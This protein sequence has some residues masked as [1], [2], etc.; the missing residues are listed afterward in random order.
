MALSSQKERQENSRIPTVYI[1]IH[2]YIQTDIL[3]LNLCFL[4]PKKS[5]CSLFLKKNKNKTKPHLYFKIYDHICMCML[6]FSSFTYCCLVTKSRPTL[7][8]PH[9]LVAC[10]ASLSMGFPRQEYWSRFPFP[11]SGGLPGPRIKPCLADVFFIAEPPMHIA[12]HLSIS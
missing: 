3:K 12:N 8:I 2:I 5:I 10:S 7:L 1:Y 6:Y 4:L 9:G 11:P